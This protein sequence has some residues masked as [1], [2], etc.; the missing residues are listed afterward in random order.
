MYDCAYIYY[1]YYYI[2]IYQQH[3]SYCGIGGNS[4]PPPLAKN[5]LIHPTPGTISSLTKG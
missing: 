1:Y 2:Y 5:V 3:F 4:S